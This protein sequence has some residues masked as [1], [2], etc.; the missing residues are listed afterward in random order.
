[1]SHPLPGRGITPRRE[2]SHGSAPIPRSAGVR[3]ASRRARRPTE[4]GAVRRGRASVWAALGALAVL[5]ASGCGIASDEQATVEPRD[6]VPFD[7]LGTTPPGTTPIAPPDGATSTRIC[8]V[9]A[10][11]R[12][13]PVERALQPDYTPTDLV[14][15]LVRGPEPS[16][17]TYGLTSALGEPETV[18]A[19]TVEGGV[20]EVDLDPAIS[21]R[22]SGDQLDVVTQLVC[23]LTDQPGVGQVRFTVDGRPIDVPTG[24]DGSLASDPVSREDYDSLIAGPGT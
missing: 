13:Y 2:R 5:T 17:R 20:A 19:V 7:L 22:P 14:D 1:M 18:L 8:L 9:G 4:Q 23:T 3:N 24:A 11:G 16:E 21:K 6:Q 12:I 10:D 15:A